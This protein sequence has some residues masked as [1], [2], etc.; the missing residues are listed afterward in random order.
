MNNTDY[1]WIVAPVSGW[2]ILGSRW[3]FRPQS[4]KNGTSVHH[5]KS[6]Q[7]TSIR[8]GPWTNL[9]KVARSNGSHFLLPHLGGQVCVHHLHLSLVCTMRRRQASRGIVMLWAMISWGTS[10]PVIHVE[11]TL[12]LLCPTGVRVLKNKPELIHLILVSHTDC[13]VL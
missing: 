5:C 12:T 1:V 11:V 6:Q 7:L 13:P 2:A 3:T 8:A 4:R 9:K 10:G